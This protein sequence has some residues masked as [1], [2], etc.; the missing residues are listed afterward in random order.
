[1]IT[2]VMEEIHERNKSYSWDEAIRKS[3][4]NLKYVEA[5]KRYLENPV[6]LDPEL[7]EIKVRIAF[8]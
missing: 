8:T 3:R 1:M 6:S 4:E 5:F 2:C 7:K